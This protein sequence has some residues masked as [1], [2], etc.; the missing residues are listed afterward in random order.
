MADITFTGNLGKDAELAYH[1][2]SGNPRLTFSVADSK[3][4][5]NGNEWETVA[6]QWLRC[7]LWGPDAEHYCDRLRKGA[8]VQVF[9][10]FFA[11]EYEHNGVQRTS[12]DV[13]V[14]GLSVINKRGTEHVVQPAPRPDESSL[15]DPWAAPSD[16]A[17]PP[18]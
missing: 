5:R 16:P 17:S 11:R 2:Q 9:G 4:K 8:R 14:R 15:A 18:F 7:T 6:E 10:E 1:P 3:S 13:T 12:L